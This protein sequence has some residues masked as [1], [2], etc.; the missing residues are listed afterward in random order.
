MKSFFRSLLAFVAAIAVTSVLS[1]GT[2]AIL[3][4]AGLMTNAALPSSVAVV[5]LIILYRTLYNVAGAFVLAKLAPSHPMRHALVLG[6]LGIIG[7]LSAMVAMPDAGP[8]Y[9]PIA[10]AILTL[11]SVWLGVKLAAPR[12]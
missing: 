5:S 10:L 1:Y 9:Y 6:V 4:A 12:R 3:V 8:A 7:T 11:P 2:D